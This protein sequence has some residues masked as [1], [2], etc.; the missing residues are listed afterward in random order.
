[1]HT[2][3]LHT[4]RLV[5]AVATATVL[6]LGLVP[7][8]AAQEPPPSP[9]P[10]S[11]T[12][13]TQVAQVGSY[14]TFSDKLACQPAPDAEG[15]GEAGEAVVRLDG[16]VVATSGVGQLSGGWLASVKV[17][18]QPGTY[19]YE[20]TCSGPGGTVT[21]A[22]QEVRVLPTRPEGVSVQVGEPVREGC[23]VSVPVTT[24]GAYTFQARVWDDQALLEETTWDTQDDTTTV[25]RWTI[26]GRPDPTFPD[27]IFLSVLVNGSVNVNDEEPRRAGVSVSYPDEVADECSAAVPV[28]AVL[29]ED[30][31]SL[32]AGQTVTVQGEGLLSGE[33]VDVVLEKTGER[34]GGVST[35]ATP[36]SRT[37]QDPYSVT[38][39]LPGDLTPGDYVLVV[40]GRISQR[41]ARLPVTVL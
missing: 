31:T 11:V 39:T 18:D 37:G 41:T 22:P 20:A 17:P 32:G 33:D 4:R 10:P 21:Y 8:S 16:E 23:T 25:I 36:R 9:E 5:V 34:V 28:T 3:R 38:A 15:A 6:L 2:R 13:S 7:A 14:V 29:A 19:T 30:P 26:T 35:G 24:T 12:V 40:Q 27:D 1:M